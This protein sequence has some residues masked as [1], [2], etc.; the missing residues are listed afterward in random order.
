MQ[1]NDI[2][3]AVETL[4][5]APA[6]IN[7]ALHVTG[8][9]ADGYHLLETLVAFTE[10]GDL[11]RIRDADKDSFSISGPFGD[12][13][14]A[15][16]GNDNI[17]TRARDLLRTAL[18][19]SNQ[20]ARPV[21]IHLEKNLPVAS[22]IG[23]GSADAAATLRGLLR[24]WKGQID[25]GSLAAIALGLGADVPMCLESQSLIARGIGEDIQPVNDLPRLFLVLANPLMAVSTPDIFRRLTSKT[26]PPL[27]ETP[28]ND[29]LAFIAASRN[30]LEAPTKALLPEIGEVSA[31]LA[32]EGASTVRMSGSGATCF[33]VFAS[34]EA[35]KK[36][37]TSL[38]SKRPGWYF[39]ATQTI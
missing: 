7:L 32:Q 10:A 31:L 28:A 21:A 24:H 30:D 35:A 18:V 11:I 20:N 5:T 17:V 33:G 15:G 3:G 1:A 37:E 26:N 13:L 38:R 2:S 36:A 9:R 34:Q 25:G 29:W 23:G 12:I 39:Q 14:R 8:Q 16:D 6:K 4:E 27:P 22:G 19:D